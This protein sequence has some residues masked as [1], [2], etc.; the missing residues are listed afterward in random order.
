M[1]RAGMACGSS[2][3]AADA[4]IAWRFHQPGDWCSAAN[5]SHLRRFRYW[6]TRVAGR[7]WTRSAFA[8]QSHA[9]RDFFDGVSD[10]LPEGM[11]DISKI[12]NLVRGLL[13]RGLSEGDVEKI[14]GGNTL[15][16]MRE[17]ETADGR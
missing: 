7:H 1:A 14:L 12:P 3:F 5:R 10:Q 8:G 6:P 17:I 15:R 4:G 9:G 13:E 2:K 11:E 16:V